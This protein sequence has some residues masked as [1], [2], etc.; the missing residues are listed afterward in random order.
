MVNIISGRNR[1]GVTLVEMLLV[2]G[3]GSL[4][5]AAVVAGAVSLQR[6]F[7]AVESNSVSQG[8]QL[9][10]LDYLAL[11]ARR[12]S[13]VSVDANLSSVT[14]TLPD[15][16]TT[17]CGGAP[18]PCPSNPKW[19]PT[20]QVVYYDGSNTT[21]AQGTPAPGKSYANAIHY[22]ISYSASGSSLGRLVAT[23]SGGFVFRG[24]WAATTDYAANDIVSS[25]NQTQT[26]VCTTAISGN[27]ANQAP[28]SDAGHWAQSTS[29][30]ISGSATTIAKNVASFRIMQP[31]QQQGTARFT[32][33]VTFNP[34][35]TRNNGHTPNWTWGAAAPSNNDG[36]VN[37]D[38]YVDQSPVY[39]PSDP[40]QIS[41]YKN[42]VYVKSNGA[43]TPDSNTVYSN[44]FLR[45][46]AAR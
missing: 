39:D 41:Y 27:A 15:Y 40:T 10:V 24:N 32:C 46:P 14:F 26:Y 17:S 11:D 22:S 13:A 29:S 28:P 8:N 9:R 38:Y 5:L 31:S 16:Y 21:G 36:S 1:A 3:C 6:S 12:A 2:V 37:G 20:N 34:V 45:N 33:S 4:I 30:Q 7:T 23:V 44:I 43:Y 42:D 19:D 35:F 18:S 25:G